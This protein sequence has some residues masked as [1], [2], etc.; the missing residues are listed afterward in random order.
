MQYDRLIHEYLDEGLDNV[1]EETLFTALAANPEVREEFNKQVKLQMAAQSDM[2]S[3]TPP[4]ESTYGV[5][6]SLGFS[7][8]SKEYL[9][10][11]GGN[12]SNNPS[13]YAAALNFWKRN[14]TTMS[15][16]LILTSFS[17]YV[18]YKAATGGG[19]F[20]FGGEKSEI[21]KENE[22]PITG[23]FDIYNDDITADKNYSDGDLHASN[24]SG[25]NGIAQVSTESQNSSNAS[26]AANKRRNITGASA[27]SNENLEKSGI[28]NDGVILSDD[29]ANGLPV[30]FLSESG[31]MLQ[32]DNKY[33]YGFGGSENNSAKTVKAVVIN[34]GFGQ[35]GETSSLPLL[36]PQ[37]DET[38]FIFQVR[39]LNESF[40]EPSALTDNFKG[41]LSFAFYYK[42]DENHGLGIEAGWENFKQ[43]FDRN[44]GGKEYKQSQNPMLFWYGLSYRYTA[45][46]LLV[47]YIF[48][49]Y[50]QV[51]VGGASTGAV[52]RTQ[53]GFQFRLHQNVTFLFGYE[54]R[55]HYFKVDNNIYN[56][57]RHGMVYG[58]NFNL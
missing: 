23:S 36:I 33:A 16:I 47:P 52:L 10:K 8:P 34:P 28:S 13:K 49:P 40:N 7:I 4:I 27:N 15:I 32:Y 57:E 1:R 29:L 51:F 2:G 48:F 44:I 25:K 3:I 42:P 5:F 46:D 55:E 45:I 19:I 22:I 21:S 31:K 41:N 11:F 26:I 37:I 17:G 20:G 18:G 24:S 30:V 53:A 9:N 38:R 54:L 12:G 6:S 58:I 43:E 39:G 56:S 14:L 50:G 35:F